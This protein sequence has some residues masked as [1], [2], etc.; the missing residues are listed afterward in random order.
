VAVASSVV[1]CLV[2]VLCARGGAPVVCVWVCS[3]YGAVVF[4][5]L[6]SVVL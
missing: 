4:V 6:I 3:C 5:G 1:A 2:C